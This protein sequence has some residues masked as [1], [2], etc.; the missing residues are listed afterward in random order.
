MNYLGKIISKLK[1]PAAGLFVFIYILFPIK[2]NATICCNPVELIKPQNPILL[3]FAVV[4][5]GN[6]INKVPL[7]T[8]SGN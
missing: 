6:V 4:E 7:G 8:L 5:A 1:L 2:L 3:K